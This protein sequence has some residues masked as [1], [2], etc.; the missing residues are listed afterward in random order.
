M[1]PLGLRLRN[2]LD[3]SRTTVFSIA[4]ALNIDVQ[5]VER[6]LPV[7]QPGWGRVG[8]AVIITAP[9]FERLRGHLQEEVLEGVVDVTAFCKIEQIDDAFFRTILP[10]WDGNWKWFGVKGEFVYGVK[11]W[12]SCKDEVEEVLS[13]E[14]R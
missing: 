4:G 2:F 7:D 1:K 12:E 5:S 10:P 14:E 9:E 8:H 13:K 3:D 11:F 6:L